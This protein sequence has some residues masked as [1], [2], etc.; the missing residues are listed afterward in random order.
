MKNLFSGLLLAI[1]AHRIRLNWF[2]LTVEDSQ[3][4]SPI[5]QNAA[6]SWLCPTIR[7]SRMLPDN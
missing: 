1:R 2:K 3:I 5:S 4:E 7:R 6:P